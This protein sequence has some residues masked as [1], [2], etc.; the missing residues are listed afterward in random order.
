M[1]GPVELVLIVAAVGYVLIRRL[2]GEPAQAKRMLVLPA[3]LSV[4]GLSDVSDAI[5][6]PMSLVFLVATAAISIALGVLRGSLVRISRRDGV[7]FIS[8][9]GIIVV[10]WV[11]NLALK[12][13]ANYAFTWVAPKEAGAVGNSMLLTLGLGILAEG[14]V[15]LYRALRSDH[16]VMW[17]QGRDGEPHQMSP[18]LDDLRHNLANRGHNPSDDNHM[19]EWN[20]RSASSATTVGDDRNPAL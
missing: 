4:I 16:P 18:F 3:V 14:L 20:I 11:I 5:K 10:V 1:N 17:A 8:Y 19:S 7:T 12:L 9:T 6:T 15:V 2:L 13:G